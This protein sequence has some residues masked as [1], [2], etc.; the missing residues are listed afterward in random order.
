MGQAPDIRDPEPGPFSGASRGFRSQSRFPEPVAVSL[1]TGKTITVGFG[2]MLRSAN[3]V[4]SRFRA[5]TNHMEDALPENDSRPLPQNATV[6]HLP[7]LSGRGN[8]NG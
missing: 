8:G 5:T 1:R 7:V 4:G 6:I 2:L 3:G